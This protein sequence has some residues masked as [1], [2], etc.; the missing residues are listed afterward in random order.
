[1]IKSVLSGSFDFGD[2]IASIVPL[3]SAGI[4][5]G[6]TA[7]RAAASLFDFL[8]IAELA[9]KDEELIHLLALGDGETVGANRNGDFF[10]K[11]ANKKYHPTFLKASYFHDHDNKDPKLAFGRVIAAAYNEPMGRVELIIGLGRDKC[12][13]DLDELEKNG[14]FPVSMSCRVPFDTCMVCGNVAKSRKDYC[15]HASIM[16]GRIMADGKMACVRNDFPDFFDISKVW[17][18]ADR[19]AFTFRKL[20]KAAAE[21]QTLGGAELAELFGTVDTL[22]PAARSAYIISKQAAL[23][24]MRAALMR[25]EMLL[26]SGALEG[27]I[28]PNQLSILKA[29]NDLGAVCN[30]LHQSGICLSLNDFMSLA[31][32]EKHA[33]ISASDVKNRI[34]TLLQETNESYG[35]RFCENGSYDG[36]TRPV[37]TK[38]ATAIRE[39]YPQFSLFPDVALKRTMCRIAHSGMQAVKFEKSAGCVAPQVEVLASEYAS[40]LIS[41]AQQAGTAASRDCELVQNLTALRVLG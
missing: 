30:A 18:G 6:W 38:V 20:E 13:G 17:R 31:G 3:H 21:G 35:Q 28:P 4:D 24:N 34:L 10:P 12:A 19:V 15:K 40:Y 37:S 14:E 36:T 7:K 32:I 5:N 23:Q 11:A 2:A 39:L 22:A 27:E 29:A 8:K 41:F 9:K 33:D 25:K 16:M 1:M 26:I